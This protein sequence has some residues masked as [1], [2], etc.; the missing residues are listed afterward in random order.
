MD[1][2]PYIS[3]SLSNAWATSTM[4]K[5]PLK[6]NPHSCTACTLS[7]WVATQKYVAGSKQLDKKNHAKCK[8]SNTKKK[9]YTKN[10]IISYLAL[11]KHLPYP[12]LSTSKVSNSNSEFICHGLMVTW[13]GWKYEIRKYDP[14]LQK[15]IWQMDKW[16]V[17]KTWSMLQIKSNSI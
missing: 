3:G 14:I 2:S 8:W 1:S 15:L 9:T 17:L 5:L 7:Q 11:W 12:V 6:Y 16:F 13:A 10:C 4:S